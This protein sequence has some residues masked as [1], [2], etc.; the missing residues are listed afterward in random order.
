M[1]SVQN[2]GLLLYIGDILPTYK[3]CFT[4]HYARMAQ[5][6]EQYFVVYVCLCR[7]GFVA[8]PHF[9]IHIEVGGPFGCLFSCWFQNGPFFFVAGNGLTGMSMVLSKCIDK[10]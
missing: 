9:L 7:N 8:H 6:A 3:D 5:R 1:S 2:P 4:S 10:L